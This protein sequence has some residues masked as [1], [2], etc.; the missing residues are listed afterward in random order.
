MH[1]CYISFMNEETVAFLPVYV[2]GII[3]KDDCV[4]FQL[5]DEN[6]L[7]FPGL[8][9]EANSLS[10]PKSTI[11]NYLSNNLHFFIKSYWLRWVGIT[12][13]V[14]DTDEF[15]VS[16]FHL[17]MNFLSEYIIENFDYDEWI[18]EKAGLIPVQI[19]D[20]TKDSNFFQSDILAVNKVKCL[21]NY[22]N[23]KKIKNEIMME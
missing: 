23:T 2:A 12:H 18:P 6:T 16:H 11:R 7:Q 22:S 1:V 14:S 20:I 3:T 9:L 5:N 10:S 8:K 15:L 13:H 4:C 19:E 17:N 21:L